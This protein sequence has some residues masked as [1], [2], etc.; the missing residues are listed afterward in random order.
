MIEKGKIGVRQFTVL[1]IL[2]TIGS[3]ILILPSGLAQEAKQDAWISASVGL[4]GGLLLIMLYNR[5][6]T[7]FPNTTL[8]HYSQEVLGKWL[9]RCL[10]L[11]YFA[12]FFLLSTLVLRNIGDFL[13]T[14]VLP[15][16][17]IHIIHIFFLLVIILGIRNGI[18]V[19]TRS[20]EIFF[21]WMM[22]FFVLLVVLLPPNFE[23]GHVLPVF[24]NGIKP[25]LRSS[26]PIMGT[27]YME[28]V[29]FL[30]VFPF[31]NHAPRARRAF[32]VGVF[33][34]GIMLIIISFLTIIVLGADLTATQIYP[35]Y[36][37][38]EKISIGQFLERLEVIMAGIWFITIYFKLAICFYVAVMTF[39]EL[40]KLK[41]TRPLYLPFGMIMIV[42]SIVVYPNIA[43]FLSFVS[44]YFFYSLPFAV[45]FPL[46][47]LIVA[48]IRKKKASE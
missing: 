6:T 13:T 7:R 1:T 45:I 18:E 32:F 37:L 39:A 8:V 30:M 44:I 41:E 12:Y 27:P 24:G 9:G 33:L 19:F 47:I 2:F 38:A 5:I 15:N 21:P 4:V 14:E 17:P 23:I 26:I 16:T 35:S 40:F 20:A 22:I 25:I 46:L 11:L 42:L 29:V 31:V 34:A 10:S 48:K 28:L 3:S 36:N 43:Y